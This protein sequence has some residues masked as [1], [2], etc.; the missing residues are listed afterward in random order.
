MVIN[1]AAEFGGHSGVG[2]ALLYGRSVRGRTAPPL[3][4]YCGRSGR[5]PLQVTS[6]WGCATSRCNRGGQCA[7]LSA[8]TH[9]LLP[10]LLTMLPGCCP[11]CQEVPPHCHPPIWACSRKCRGN[12]SSP[13]CDTRSR[14]LGTEV[15]FG[16]VRNKVPCCFPGEYIG[17]KG[18]LGPVFG[19]HEVDFRVVAASALEE[20][21]WALTQGSRA[22]TVAF[23]S[24]LKR[25]CSQKR[26]GSEGIGLFPNLRIDRIAGESIAGTKLAGKGLRPHFFRSTVRWWRV[27]R[28]FFARQL[29]SDSC[30]PQVGAVSGDGGS[31][32]LFRTK[33]CF[34]S[35]FVNFIIFS[36]IFIFISGPFAPPL[37]PFRFPA[38]D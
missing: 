7:A 21:N 27:P 37:L 14:F 5:R 26:E 12:M 35:F 16:A 28:T 34:L 1:S 8:T 15:Y 13:L 23:E 6:Q 29:E 36:F 32:C 3:S 17:F 9:P 11:E 38:L 22:S 30:S 25:D 31:S 4:W 2:V 33:T 20:Q 18:R 19:L 24:L 10:H